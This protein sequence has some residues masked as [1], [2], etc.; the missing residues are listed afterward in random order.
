MKLRKKMIASAFLFCAV[1]L[2]FLSC[3]KKSEIDFTT[4]RLFRPT[5]FTATV[6]GVTVD[7]SWKAIKNAAYL[8][9][10]SRD[11]LQFEQELQAFSTDGT[12]TYQLT[13]LRSSTMY[14]ARIKAVSKISEVKDSEY[15]Q[16]V[17]VTEQEN[18]FFGLSTDDIFSDRIM[19]HWDP[20]KTVTHIT[21]S[22]DGQVVQTLSL[23][24]SEMSS[25]ERLVTGLAASTMYEF[26][27][28]NGEHAL[29]GTVAAETLPDTI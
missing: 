7:L 17:F 20:T 13:D 25:G 21:V 2:A 8:L 23:T 24:E 22:S 12:T 27:I 16:I 26:N 6:N 1:S 9:E 14:S 15:Q 18:I 29:R 10:V 28:Y 5:Q 3:L 11:S 4:D 19:L